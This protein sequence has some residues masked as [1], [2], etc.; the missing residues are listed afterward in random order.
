[1]RRKLKWYQ[2]RRYRRIWFATKRISGYSL[3]IFGSLLVLYFIA[4]FVLSH[5]TVEG[6]NNKNAGIKI[7]LM[8]SGVH[9]DFVV[10]IQHS[11]K[12]WR[13]EFPVANTGFKDSTTKLV[14]IGWGDQHFYMNTPEWADL[15]LQTAVTAPLGLGPSALHATYYYEVLDDRPVIALHL[16]DKQYQQ[17]VHYIERTLVRDANGKS[18]YIQAT[19]PG[20]VSGNDA[21]Y[22]AKGSY[23]LFRTC[24]S[25]INNGL[26]ACQ[27]KAC[28]WTP[29]AGGIFY[30]YGK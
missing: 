29:F 11:I 12:D 19:M 25:W 26:K 23:S 13:K 2:K 1:M 4:A 16:S 24:N 9:T 5:L 22:K 14:S 7:Y 6:I 10:P 18:I 3:T 30:Q 28:Y 21:Y 27:Q 20:V 15:T 8:K 17:L